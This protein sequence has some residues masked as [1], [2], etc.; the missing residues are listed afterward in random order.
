[1]VPFFHGHV[2]FHRGFLP[3][4]HQVEK[5]SF[6]QM[7][8]FRSTGCAWCIGL[9]TAGVAGRSCLAAVQGGSRAFW[10]GSILLR[11]GCCVGA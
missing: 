7:S 1:M 9:L 8:P 11:E 4:R 3:S 6:P 5:I 2:E 10:R